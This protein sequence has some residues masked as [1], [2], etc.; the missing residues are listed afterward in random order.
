VDV[1]LAEAENGG[2]SR[3]LRFLTYSLAEGLSIFNHVVFIWVGIHRL[4][5]SGALSSLPNSRRQKPKEKIPDFSSI[6]KGIQ[7][8]SMISNGLAT[9]IPL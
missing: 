1:R 9:C 8:D 7:L 2:E 3:Q 4:A 6:Y 5:L